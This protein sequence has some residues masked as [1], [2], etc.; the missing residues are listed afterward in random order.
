MSTSLSSK[1]KN[2]MRKEGEKKELDELQIKE[3]APKQNQLRLRWE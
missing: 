2:I 3:I 1:E